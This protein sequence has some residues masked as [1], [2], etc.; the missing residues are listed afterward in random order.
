[1][2]TEG[3][4]LAGAA[5]AAGEEGAEE[6][7]DILTATADQDMARQEK[8]QN[9]FHAAEFGDYE[10]LKDFFTENEIPLEQMVNKV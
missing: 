4:A 9:L 2:E 10:K 3:I 1:M 7:N 8:I 6:Q 5:A